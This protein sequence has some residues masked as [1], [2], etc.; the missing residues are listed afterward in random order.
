MVV[1]II[2][3]L[4][5]WLVIFVAE[6]CKSNAFY[7]A[8]A[9]FRV[10]GMLYVTSLVM[11]GIVDPAGFQTTFGMYPVKFIL[12]VGLAGGYDAV[13]FLV[14]LYRPHKYYASYLDVPRQILYKV[15]K[16]GKCQVLSEKEAKIAHE[17]G[18]TVYI[19]AMARVTYKPKP[20]EE[21][22]DT[23]KGKDT[24]MFMVRDSKGNIIDVKK[25]RN[26]TQEEIQE[27]VKFMHAN[28]KMENPK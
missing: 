22:V 8:T 1:G 20:A 28:T 26:Y 17:K 11:Y 19:H 25:G 5:A 3:M 2:F 14:E 27:L 12:V 21:K 23:A 6:A 15:G 24:E 4:I 10:L 13:M 18:E 9:I 7:R 16:Y